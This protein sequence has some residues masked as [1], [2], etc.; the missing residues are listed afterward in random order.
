M[1]LDIIH[2]NVRTW[3]RYKNNLSN[4]YLTHNPDII[5]INSHGLDSN[6]DQFLKIFS[7]SNLTTGNGPHS[8]TAILCKL[9]KN[10]HTLEPPWILILFI[11]SSTPILAKY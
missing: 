2:H 11:P 6:K 7:Y 4:Y 5:S 1:R 3:G 8:G 9:I 10:M